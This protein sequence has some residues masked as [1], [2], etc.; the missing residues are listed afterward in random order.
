MARNATLESVLLKYRAEIRASAN[1]AHNLSAR[2]NQVRLLQRVQEEKWEEYDWPHLRIRR[3]VPAQ[4]GQRYYD[5]PEDL[6]IDRLEK[7][8]VR[9]NSKWVDL[10]PG[11]DANHYLQW[12]SDLDQRSWP[13]ERWARYEDDQ[14][15]IWPIPSDN[16]D[17]ET[18]EGTL[19]FIGIRKLGAF[20]ADDDRADLDDMLIALFAAAETLAGQDSKDAPLKLRAAQKRL[21]TLTGNQSKQ[22]KFR[23]FGCDGPEPRRPQ[24]PPTVHYRTT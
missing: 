3:D 5:C 24:G 11:I 22:S 23:M 6:P 4:A 14:I 1:V 21:L 7:I 13:V 16:A 18:L 15:E 10:D 8:Q 17:T 9:Y 2:E 19:R 12:D 20:V